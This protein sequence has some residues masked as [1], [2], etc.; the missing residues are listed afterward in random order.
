M[1]SLDIHVWYNEQG[2]ILAIGYA[3]DGSDCAGRVIPIPSHGQHCLHANVPED[4]LA[5]LHETYE[6]DVN[7]KALTRKLRY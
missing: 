4:E 5:K 1:K 7:A 6:V 3:R 2:E